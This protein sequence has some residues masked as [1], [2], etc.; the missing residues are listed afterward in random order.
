MKLAITAANK[1]VT[2]KTRLFPL[3]VVVSITVVLVGGGLVFPGA[4]VVDTV[5]LDVAGEAVEELDGGCSVVE[6]SKKPST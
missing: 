5:L 3:P 6:G 4:L 1:I 2:D